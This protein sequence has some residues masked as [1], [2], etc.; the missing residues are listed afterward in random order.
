M[1]EYAIPENVPPLIVE[2][3]PRPGVRQVSLSAL[4]REDV[5]V[6]SSEAMDNAMRVIQGMAQRVTSALNGLEV[7]ARPSRAEI[8]FGVKLDTE[9]GAIVSKNEDEATLKVKLVMTT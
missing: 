6:E 9:G 3:V 2:L 8:E 7:E 5:A 4:S 1:A